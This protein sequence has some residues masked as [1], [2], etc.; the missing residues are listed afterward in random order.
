[1]INLGK[2]SEDKNKQAYEKLKS[3]LAVEVEG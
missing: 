2:M 1:M 3:V